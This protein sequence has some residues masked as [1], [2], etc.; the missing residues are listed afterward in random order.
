MANAITLVTCVVFNA[1][2]ETGCA[3]VLQDGFETTDVVK[4][5]ALEQAID[6][7]SDN[8]SDVC[9]AIYYVSVVTPPSLPSVTV[10]INPKLETP[11]LAVE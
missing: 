1:D 6:N 7:F 5:Q 3:S 4:E 8:F 10:S 9:A 11:E 2:G